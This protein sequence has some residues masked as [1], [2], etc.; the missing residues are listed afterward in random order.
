MLSTLLSFET[1]LDKTAGQAGFRAESGQNLT[2]RVG[3]LLGAALSLIGV[4][5]LV[6]II[7][8]GF[9]WMTAAGDQEKVKKAKNL[10]TSAIIGLVIIAAGYAIV[11]FVLESVL[12]ATGVVT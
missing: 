12:K 7:Y 8:G 6:L 11:R 9:L 3:A 5:F 10:I 1:G 2:E 4:V